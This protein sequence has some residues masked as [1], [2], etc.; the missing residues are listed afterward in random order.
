MGK[1]WMKHDSLTSTNT[2]LSELLKREDLEEGTVVITDFQDAG[3]GQGDHSWESRRGEN[4]LMSVLLFPAFLSAT[5]QFHL[6]RLVSLAICDALDSLGIEAQIKWPNDILA[7]K[8]KIAGILIEHSVT[9]GNIAHTIAGIGLNLNQTEFP[10]FPV[11]ASSLKLECGKDSDVAAVGKLVNTYIWNRY[12]DLKAGLTDLL[13]RD[14]KK[15]MYRAGMP[16]QF[17]SA[18]GAFEGIVEGVNNYGELL[19]RCGKEIRAFGHGSVQ[20]ELVFDGS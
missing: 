15:R 7:S 13:E 20:M 1:R 9:A 3:R 4:L 10:A 6:S 12:G 19:V 5:E 2:W 16:A 18:E 11:P 14:Y 17:K 8:G